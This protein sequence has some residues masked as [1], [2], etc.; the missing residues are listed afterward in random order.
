QIPEPKE[1]CFGADV[2]QAEMVIIDKPHFIKV[3]QSVQSAVNKKIRLECQ[4]DEDRKVRVEWTKDGN[5]I[6]PGKDYKIYFEDKIASLEIP[7]AKLKDSGHYVCTVS[8]EAGSSSSSASV[9]VREPPSFVKK[10]DP[11]YLLTPGDSARLQCKVK[12][13]PEI[14]VSWFKDN[15]KIL[16]SSASLEIKHL[17]ASD[18][19][20]YI[21]RATNSAGSKDSSSTLFIKG[22]AISTQLH[23][24]T[25]VP[26]CTACIDCTFQGHV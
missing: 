17:D 4:V 19:G 6:P 26:G 15:K 13:S 18:A 7:L 3:L 22:L 2:C 1:G 11:S 25:R 21:C 14:Q 24:R 20:V 10:V 8:N 16:E 9:A 5:K 23:C 12:G